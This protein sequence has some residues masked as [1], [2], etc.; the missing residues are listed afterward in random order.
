MYDMTGDTEIGSL[1]HCPCVAMQ[2]SHTKKEIL[3]TLFNGLKRLEYRGYDS[4]GVSID[5]PVAVR[6]AILPDQ[7]YLFMN[8]PVFSAGQPGGVSI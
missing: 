8:F 5:L 3:D 1:P 4:A 2:V 6:A 7:R